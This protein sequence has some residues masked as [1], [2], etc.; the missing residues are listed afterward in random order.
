MGSK[1]PHVR[2]RADRMK[3]R[4]A[5]K[6]TRTNEIDISPA[7]RISATQKVV[8]MNERHHGQHAFSIYSNLLSFCLP[9]Q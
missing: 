2:A 5:R 1:D 6:E 3:H 9:L 4:G 8:T 7:L